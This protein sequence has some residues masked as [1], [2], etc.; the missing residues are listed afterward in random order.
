[1]KKITL[2]AALPLAAMVTA[3]TVAGD[4]KPIEIG[5][6]VPMVD[7]KMENVL[8]DKQ[9]S[10][11][12]LKTDKGLLVIFSCNTCPYVVVSEKRIQ[13]I[14]AL[15]QRMNIGIAMI[16]SNEAKRDAD[17]SKDAMKKYAA[18]Q[19]YTAPYL[20]DVNSALA[21]AFGATRTPECFLFDASGKLVY[22]GAIDDSVKDES[23]VK[24]HYLSDAMAAVAKGKPVAEQNTVSVGCTIKRKPAEQK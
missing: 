13:N 15:A 9:V 21:D 1:M 16:N 14:Q 2:F 22:H 11:N 17:D 8:N 18:E 4:I 5:S 12:E 10:L 23:A 6:S 7:T 24:K 19:K 3:F 20:I